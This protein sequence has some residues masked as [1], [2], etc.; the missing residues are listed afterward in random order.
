VIYAIAIAVY[1]MAL[2][3]GYHFGY[4]HRMADANSAIDHLMRERE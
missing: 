1:L 4:Q 3:I 2:G